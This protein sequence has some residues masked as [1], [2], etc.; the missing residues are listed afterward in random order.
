MVTPCDSGCRF[1]T[2]G[3]HTRPYG[4]RKG[5]DDPGAGGLLDGA[6]YH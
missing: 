5:Q 3:V 1:W 2:T 4:P 6:D